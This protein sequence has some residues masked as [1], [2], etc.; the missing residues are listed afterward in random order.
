MSILALNAGSSS[1]KFGLFDDN[2]CA[3]LMTGEFDWADGNLDEAQL[4]VRPRHGTIVRS[5]LPLP[6]SS[7]AAARAIRVAL[8]STPSANIVAVGHRIVHGGDDYRA[9][10]IIDS[11]VKETIG[12]WGELSSLHN[13]PA[14]KTI[15]AV[16]EAL[17]GTPQ[18]AV[19]DTAFYANMPLRAC[20]YAAPFDWYERWGIRRF[21]FHGI[22]HAYCASR[23]AAML[24]RNLAD[25]RIVSCHLGGGCSATAIQGGAPVATTGGFSPLEGLMMGTRCGTI[26]PGALIHLQRKAGMS[27]KELDRSLNHFSG[28]LGIS[29]VSPNLAQIEIA[30]GQGNHRARLAFEMFADQVR[31]AIGRLATTMGGIDVLTFTDRAGESSPALRAAVCQGLEFMGIRVNTKLN[32]EARAD[33]DIAADNSPARIMVVHTEEELMVARETRRVASG[34]FARPPAQRPTDD[35]EVTPQIE[36]VS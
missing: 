3:P 35:E 8:D 33:M 32:A 27:C 29:G 4:T 14:L 5:R 26:D 20:L 23:A 18:T 10:V 30:A 9:S 21:G 34:A 19:F 11:R 15:E 17:P 2:D 7:N 6:D 24:G 25:L 1:L 22:S 36:L 28:L 16:E 12:R 13:P 31:G